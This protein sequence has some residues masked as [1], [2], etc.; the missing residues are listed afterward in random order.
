MRVEIRQRLRHGGRDQFE[1][2]GGGVTAVGVVRQQVALDRRQ[3]MPQVLCVGAINVLAVGELGRCLRLAMVSVAAF[4]ENSR[5][6][7]VTT[8]CYRSLVTSMLSCAFTMSA[9]RCH[10][11]DRTFETIEFHEIGLIGTPP[12]ST[13][14]RRLME[15]KKDRNVCLLQRTI[16]RSRSHE[17]SIG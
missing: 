13:R 9:T 14:P 3:H 6:G 10:C 5:G 15:P 4:C 12:V 7:A 16:D 2:L 11:A 17:L 1:L 8:I